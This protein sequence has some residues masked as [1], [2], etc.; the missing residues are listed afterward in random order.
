MRIQRIYGNR[1]QKLLFNIIVHHIIIIILVLQ[2]R[3]VIGFVRSHKNDLRRVK[4]WEPKLDEKRDDENVEAY[5]KFFLMC[6]LKK[7]FLMCELKILLT[8]NNP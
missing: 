2:N 5:W 8:C 6:E 7:F 1:I 3:C 4:I